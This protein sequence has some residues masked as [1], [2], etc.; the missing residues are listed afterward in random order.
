[1]AATLACGYAGMTGGISC[2]PRV[3][4][5]AYD[6]PFELHRSMCVAI[7]SLRGSQVMR[8]VLGDEFVTLYCAVKD[9][10]FWEFEERVPAWEQKELAV[11]V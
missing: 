1:M 2:R 8:D 3:V 7:D 9:R 11:F 5:S 4:G 6:V 10:E